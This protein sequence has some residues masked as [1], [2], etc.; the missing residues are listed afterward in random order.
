M[1]MTKKIF[2]FAIMLSIAFSFSTKVMAQENQPKIGLVNLKHISE[3]Y[4]KKIDVEEYFKTKYQDENVKLRELRDKVAG[5]KKQIEETP[6]RRDSIDFIELKHK[7][8]LAE[9]KLKQSYEKVKTLLDTEKQKYIDEITKEIEDE[10][11]A[12]AKDSKFD[13]ILRGNPGEL[14]ETT[15]VLYQSNK[16]DVSQSII[17][18]LNAK[19]EKSEKKIGK[20]K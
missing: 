8:Q 3:S 16:I 13:I 19:Y 10:I 9:L 17:D 1:D 2:L 18:R 14:T 7:F 20:I 4:K 6:L 12:F 5:L 11:K 15:M